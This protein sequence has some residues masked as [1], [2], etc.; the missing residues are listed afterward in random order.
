V[1]R[2]RGSPLR[3]ADLLPASLMGLGLLSAGLSAPL[4]LA[5]GLIGALLQGRFEQSLPATCSG[6][7]TL[8]SPRAALVLGSS[9]LHPRQKILLIRTKV[10]VVVLQ[11][12]RA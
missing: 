2:P 7:L 12:H 3:L 6:S 10:W 11:L 4:I 9:C 1:L 5:L 8:E